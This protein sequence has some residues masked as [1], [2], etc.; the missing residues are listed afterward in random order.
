MASTPKG[1]SRKS[2][3][4]KRR[5]LTVLYEDGAYLAVD[6]P[7]G[8][9]VHGGAGATGPSVLDR[10]EEERG[11]LRLHLVH[12]LDRGTSGVLLL[13]KTAAAARAAQEAWDSTKKT[14]AAIAAG[15]PKAPRTFDA[16]L[17]GPDGRRQSART[18]L[19]SADPLPGLDASSCELELET[20]RTHQIRRHLAAA[21]HPVLLDERHG[22]FAK[23]RSF[24]AQ[25]QNL[26]LPRPKHLYLSCQKLH[27][28][29]GLGPRT[30]E[31]PLPRPWQNLRTATT[32]SPHRP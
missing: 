3:G 12:R 27:L 10:L 14:Y 21:G 26:G 8:I 18:E 13:A 2:P 22:D 23:N 32:P 31:A 25:V 11:G 6:K 24:I 5:P 7:A 9:P 1:R 30:L 15:T 17:L 19:L 28:P 4:A 20:G 29:P 16:P